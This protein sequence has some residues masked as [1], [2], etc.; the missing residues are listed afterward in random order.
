MDDDEQYVGITFTE[1]SLWI[2]GEGCDATADAGI[3]E[4]LWFHITGP[5]DYTVDRKHERGAF[6][7]LSVLHNTTGSVEVE[8]LTVQFT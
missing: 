4:A 5:G 6:R 2:S 1:S 8:E 3:D 7:Y